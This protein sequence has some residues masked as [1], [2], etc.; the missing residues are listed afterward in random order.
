[1]ARPARKREPE[2]CFICPNCGAE[3]PA[4]ARACP[5]CGSDEQTGW[6]QDADTSALPAGY[7]KDEEFDYA[8]FLEREFG[9]GRARICGLPRAV[10][11][12]LATLCTLALLAWLLL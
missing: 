4:R 12:A 10:V 3:V 5:E 11:L 7:G 8:D 6:S 1:M 9:G 2:G